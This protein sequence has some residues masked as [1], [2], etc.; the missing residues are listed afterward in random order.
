MNKLARVRVKNI[1]IDVAR[2]EIIGIIK[3]NQN[4]C[5]VLFRKRGRLWKGLAFSSDVAQFI[6]QGKEVSS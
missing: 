6:G 3:L 5:E 2:W 4:L 1:V